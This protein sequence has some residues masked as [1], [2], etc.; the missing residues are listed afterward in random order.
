MPAPAPTDRRDELPDEEVP[1]PTLGITPAQVAGSAL[2]SVSGA[3]LAS[4]LG[5]AGTLIG[6]AM[7]SIVATVG[8]A[9]YTYSLRASSQ[10]ITIRRRPGGRPV[11]VE[12]R[13]PWWRAL[14]W[15]RV[16]L[17]SIA[18]LGVSLLA[19]TA[20]EGLTGKPVSSL[21]T[22]KDGGGTTI[23]RAVGASGTDSSPD[24][25]PDEPADIPTDDTT[26][27]PTTDPS[28]DPS[29]TPEPSEEP[30]PAETPAPTEP[31]TSEPTPSQAPTAD[32][33][34]AP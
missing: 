34:V 1:R 28:T 11:Q 13:E 29:P 19:L 14:P 17:A 26:P 12:E 21:T 20:F 24:D 30:S 31:P 4:W 5:V 7:L 8:S 10:V 23:S 2:A 33:S 6:A 27:S 32:P 25:Q 3:V 22:G 18:V 16:A 15:P 9:A